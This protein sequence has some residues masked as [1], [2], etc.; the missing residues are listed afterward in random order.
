MSA[1]LQDREIMKKWYILVLSMACMN[2]NSLTAMNPWQA[3]KMLAK[4]KNLLV[5]KKSESQRQAEIE[6]YLR[7]LDL[8]DPNICNDDG[9]TV[10]HH[11]VLRYVGNLYPFYLES[12]A[13]LL[14]DPRVQCDLK[15]NDGF[16]AFE[17][18]E[19][20]E[21]ILHLFNNR[22]RVILHDV[23]IAAV[24]SKDILVVKSCLQRPEL[25]IND[26]CFGHTALDYAVL[27]LDYEM[28]KELLTDPDLD[29][30]VQDQD[31]NTALH[32]LVMWGNA[33]P[34]VQYLELMLLLL[35]DSRMRCNVP[36]KDG[37]TILQLMAAQGA[38][39]P[40]LQN[41]SQIWGLGR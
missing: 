3:R 35:N 9:N 4:V 25:A 32:L 36:N 8:Y 17:L 19:E 34:S 12:I 1:S 22:D 31:G 10:L 14:R 30:N 24:R 2:M 29:P 28:V 15:N 6:Q 27:Q 13:V 5:A 37:K 20:H 41:L 39:P 23:F 40:I 33:C 26:L 11:L 38:Q 7:N 16:T 18:A 21:E